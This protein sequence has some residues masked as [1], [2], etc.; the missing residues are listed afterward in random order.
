MWFQRDGGGPSSSG[1][2]GLPVWEPNWR[3]RYSRVGVGGGGVG[4][5]GVLPDNGIT[6]WISTQIQSYS[7]AKGD[8]V[9]HPPKVLD[10]VG[11]A[12]GGGGQ[13]MTS[14]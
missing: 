8:V 10:G 3:Y 13:T 9:K 11:G 6:S 7:E 1:R 2:A 12:R 4:E 14:I 5:V